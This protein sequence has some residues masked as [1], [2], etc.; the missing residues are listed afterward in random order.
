ML[1]SL[2]VSLNHHNS[3]ISYL[4][5]NLRLI[6]FNAIFTLAGTCT[7]KA[8]YCAIILSI[9]SKKQKKGSR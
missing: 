1:F 4:Y 3:T 6:F 7:E 9:I 2:L 5:L 8:S